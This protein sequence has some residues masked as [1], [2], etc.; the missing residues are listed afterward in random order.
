MKLTKY[1]LFC[2]IFPILFSISSCY[3]II[4]NGSEPLIRTNS[5]GQKFPA[6]AHS[7]YYLTK[8]ID[9]K[10]QTYILSEDVTIRQSGGVIKNGTLIGNKTMIHN[11]KALFERVSI[12]GTWY[13]ENIST[14]FFVDLTYKNSLRDVLALASPDVNNKIMIKKG[15]YDI[16]LDE[17]NKN[18]IMIPS[19]TDVVIDGTICLAPNSLAYYEIVKA[20]GNDISIS[21]KGSIIGDK[22]NHLGTSGEWGMGL[23]IRG[24]DIRIRN[25]TIKDCWGDCIYINTAS[26]IH[27][28]NCILD[29]GRRQGIS[30]T[31]GKNI[32][33]MN[34]MI[35]NVHGTAPQF[36]I[37]LEPNKGDSVNNIYIHK[38]QIF[39][40]VGGITANG[41]ANN[42]FL[43]NVYIEDC[44][45]DENVKANSYQ[46]SYA[47][48]VSIKNCTA[49]N[50]SRKIKFSHIN[51]VET[52]M[53]KVGGKTNQEIFSNCKMINGIK[54]SK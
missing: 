10:G 17:K 8:D 26:K 5:L 27:I 2:F 14:D 52:K 33:I 7:V 39:N 4:A 25:I 46:F 3:G 40:C 50:N 47:N 53:N 31:S 49:K 43:G 1:F 35:K 37:D 34:C 51:T 44:F 15:I 29:N 42:A 45:V 11:S 20:Q 41:G 13:V 38:T 36:A 12:Q 48:K 28:E 23:Y 21:G 9:L 16:S 19:N 30:I 32:Y 24:N 18:G 22:G 6:M 54:S